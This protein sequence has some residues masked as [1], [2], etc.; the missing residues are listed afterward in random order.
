MGVYPLEVDVDSKND[1]ARS[2]AGLAQTMGQYSCSKHRVSGIGEG[3]VVMIA[4]VL[5]D[6]AVELDVARAVKA[7]GA[8][9]IGLFPFIREDGNHEAS[10]ESQTLCDYSFD[11]LSGDVFGVLKVEGY[12]TKMIPTTTMMN[13]YIFWALVGSYV[14]AMEAKGEAPYYWMSYHVPGGME[15]DTQVRPH[16]ERRGY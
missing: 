7:S 3:D 4:W 9:L 10:E 15:Y 12:E 8:S 6:P 1:D 16:F 2:E 14:T 13:N 11:N 5:A